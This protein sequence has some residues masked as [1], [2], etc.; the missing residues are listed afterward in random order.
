MSYE[1]R[2]SSS[3]LNS[4]LWNENVAF[5]YFTTCSSIL[6]DTY[7]NESF[8]GLFVVFRSTVTFLNSEFL[9]TK[10]QREG[11]NVFWTICPRSVERYC[12]LLCAL[13]QWQFRSFMT[14]DVDH[15]TISLYNR[16]TAML[17]LKDSLISTSVLFVESYTISAS[18]TSTSH[19]WRHRRLHTSSRCTTSD[20]WRRLFWF[21]TGMC[22]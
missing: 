20:W 6:N 15:F 8:L 3:N 9:Y 18:S 22:F 10:F 14:R 11:L 1:S 7:S 21:G 2:R 5:E 17:M 19:R 4:F 12:Q 16:Y 13:M